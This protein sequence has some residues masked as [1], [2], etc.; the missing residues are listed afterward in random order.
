MKEVDNSWTLKELYAECKHREIGGCSHLN[1]PDLIH[2]L[3]HGAWRVR[4]LERAKRHVGAFHR[5]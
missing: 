5:T 3:N 4:V 1:K 2:K